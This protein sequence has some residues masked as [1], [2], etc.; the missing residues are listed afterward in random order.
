MLKVNKTNVEL[1]PTDTP[2]TIRLRVA[3]SLKTI[4]EFLDKQEFNVNQENTVA[5]FFS[6]ND[7]DTIVMA[8]LMNASTL[9]ELGSR[10]SSPIFDL[11]RKLYIV[12]KIQ[13][14]IDDFGKNET[15]GLNY[16]LFELENELGNVF[17]YQTVWNN[18]GSIIREFTEMVRNSSKQILAQTKAF[19]VWSRIKPVFKTT[20]FSLNKVHHETTV[21]NFRNLNEYMVFDSIQLDD[22]II[23]CFYKDLI[24]FNS[25]YNNLIDNY[26][27]QDSTT[28]KKAKI[29]DIVRILLRS[30]TIINT[31]VKD[32]TI[33]FTTE[34]AT[35]SVDGADKTLIRSER[36]IIQHIVNALGLDETTSNRKEFFYG[37]YSA[38]IHIPLLVMK[39]LV[40]N[41]PTVISLAY[42]NESAIIN[43]RRTNLN[44]FLKTMDNIGVGLFEKPDTV[45]TFV[46]IKKIFGGDD[47]QEK[48]AKSMDIVNKLLTYAASRVEEVSNYYNEYISISLE[49]QQLKESIEDKENTL[50]KLVPDIFLPNYTRLCAKPPIIIDDPTTLA[51]NENVLE[52]PIHGELE[53]KIYKCP[54]SDFKYPGLRKN[55]LSNK[56]RFPFVPCC[57][58]QPQRNKASY[59]LYYNEQEFK[60][61]INSGEVGKTLKILSPN[62]IGE[63]PPNIAKLLQYTTG[64]KFYRFGIPTSLNSC[65]QI[66]HIAQQ[67][68]VAFNPTN[69][70]RELAKRS[71][72]CKAEMS[73]FTNDEIS[74]KL[75]DNTVYIDPKLFKGALEDYF[76]L[77]FILF[78][79]DEDDF[80]TYPNKFLRFICPLKNRVVF[81]IEHESQKH[82]ELIID[83]ETSGYINKQTQRPI[84]YNLRSDKD[85]KKIFDLYVERFNYI[86]YDTDNNVLV[87]HPEAS[88]AVSRI[89]YM[90]PWEY[91]T[92]N[93]KIMRHFDP[94]TQYIDNYGKTRLVEFVMKNTPQT[95]VAKFEPLPCINIEIKPLNHFLQINEQ[96]SPETKQELKT[97]SWLNLYFGP[98]QKE[99]KFMRFLQF[100]KL[101]EYLFWA[102]CHLYS[103]SGKSLDNWLDT[104]TKVV[105]GY[106]YSA[107][108]VKPYFEYDELM[109][110]T[111]PKFI[112]D[113]KEFQNRVRYN[114]SLISSVNLKFYNQNLYHQYYQDPKNFTLIHP[115]QL[116][117]NTHEYFQKTR[118]PYILNILSNDNLKYIRVNTLYLI[119]DLFGYFQDILCLVL[120]SL[121][122]V[123]E[124]AGKRLKMNTKFNPD[125]SMIKI[126]LFDPDNTYPKIYVIGEKE[127]LIELI[128]INVNKVW[129]YGLILKYYF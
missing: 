31:F 51:T 83:E 19:D 13:S 114:L 21:E 45:G 116:A 65:I 40:T 30:G 99:S 59:K 49:M 93:G 44:L 7:K 121:D 127:P 81:M 41:D 126:Y 107:V 97:Y 112:F 4:P 101:A 8:P 103:I 102:A 72:L 46:R 61:R 60:Q 79:K 55:L 16:A 29:L 69:I 2:E 66:M 57:Y 36:Q 18:R 108:T 111:E 119:K 17:D 24:K 1:F 124:E 125:E 58:Q 113:S 92:G 86:L 27:Y 62:R 64:K 88:A 38:L 67:S 34:F 10:V 120:P 85:I 15:M 73:K 56:D 25:E 14:T 96:L 3:T 118:K 91:Q 33:T 26:L 100:K 53:P 68:E 82:V 117:L 70:R 20:Q 87:N 43:T 37:S 89:P 39:E 77:S 106:K 104:E 123:F 28:L 75:L 78:S 84:F 12:S 128:I 9:D 48:V 47:L 115:T 105:D 35:T 80:T 109:I 54:Y 63:L 22:S 5:P 98:P 32:K 71:Q 11:A 50:K 74:K 52:F 23:G 122:K 6:I 42:I 90:Y 110:G 95:F 76:E 94:K 129:F